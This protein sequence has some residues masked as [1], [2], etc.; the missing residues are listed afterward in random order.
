M[1]IKTLGAVHSQ[2]YNAVSYLVLNSVWERTRHSAIALVRDV[3][4][5]GTGAIINLTTNKI[6]RKL[7]WQKLP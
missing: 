6:A 4:W 1:K 5:A 7:Y 2:R 3:A